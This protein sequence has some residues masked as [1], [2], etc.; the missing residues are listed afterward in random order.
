MGVWGVC[1]RMYIQSFLRFLKI[2][3][4]TFFALLKEGLLSWG[5][6]EDGGMEEWGCIWM[7]QAR[8]YQ[9]YYLTHSVSNNTHNG[10]TA[11]L[12]LRGYTQLSQLCWNTT[13]NGHSWVYSDISINSFQPFFFFFLSVKWPETCLQTFTIWCSQDH[14]LH[15]HC[16]NQCHNKWCGV[17][18]RCWQDEGGLYLIL[19]IHRDNP[20]DPVASRQSH[21]PKSRH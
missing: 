10:K 9:Y 3:F 19:F 14:P 17:C 18:H 8:Q 12:F 4:A 1:R 7:R 15:Q 5:R 16:R 20:L 13:Q 6:E 21:S 2:I 11:R